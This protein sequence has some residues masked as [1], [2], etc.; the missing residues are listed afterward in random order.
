MARE[1]YNETCVEISPK[2][3]NRERL[4]FEWNSFKSDKS[5]PRL[6]N[7]RE[8]VH[9]TP[10]ELGWNLFCVLHSIVWAVCVCLIRKGNVGQWVRNGVVTA[11]TARHA[12]TWFCHDYISI[13]LCL[14]KKKST[15]EE[16][17]SRRNESRHKRPKKE[18]EKEAEEN[19]LR[20]VNNSKTCSNVAALHV[21]FNKY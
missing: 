1:P 6:R 11:T 19:R 16:T 3:E 10:T 17:I 7:Q 4:D 15:S 12:T 8:Q 9:T 2:K 13:L 20:A 21:L 18:E 14:K 5:D